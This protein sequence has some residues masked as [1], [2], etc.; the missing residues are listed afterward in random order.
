MHPGQLQKAQHPVTTGLPLTS[1]QSEE[2]SLEKQ[3]LKFSSM[4]TVKISF[5]NIS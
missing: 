2:L 1:Q 3:C 5:L 4:Q